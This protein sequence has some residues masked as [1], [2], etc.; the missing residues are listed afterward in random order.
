MNTSG[1]VNVSMNIELSDV[2]EDRVDTL[3]W[4]FQSYI[5]SLRNGDGVIRARNF[6]A[7]AYEYSK[8]DAPTNTVS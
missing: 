4:S 3:W 1:K 8:D 2:P 6:S 7:G 5:K